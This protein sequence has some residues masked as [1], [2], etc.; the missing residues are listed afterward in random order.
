MAHTT[1]SMVYRGPPTAYCVSLSRVR[2]ASSGSSSTTSS[3]SAPLSWYRMRRG[4]KSVTVAMN[5]CERSSVA[6][7]RTEGSF[8]RHRDRKVEKSF[9]LGGV[10]EE[11]GRG[12]QGGGGREGGREGGKKGEEGR[13]REGGRKG[14]REWGG[15]VSKQLWSLRAITPTSLLNHETP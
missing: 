12:G 10:G 3:T 5:G 13:G 4:R 11:V 8:W 7:A 15:T 1:H 9:D 14:G 2:S 6:E